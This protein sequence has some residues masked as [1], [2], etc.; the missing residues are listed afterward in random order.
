MSLADRRRVEEICHGALERDPAER[1]AFVAHACAGDEALRLEVE[2]L[3]AHADTADRFLSDQLPAAAADA[4]ASRSGTLIGQHIGSCQIV[5]L[6]GAGG[7]AEV[8]R[9][10][11]TEL[12]RDVAIKILPPSYVADRGR[13]ARFEREARAVAALNHPNIVTIHSIEML[14]GQPVLVMELVEGRSLTEV[15]PRQGLP[16]DKFVQIA[17]PLADAIGTAHDKGITHRDLK[18]GNVMVTPEGRVKVLDFGL[19][20][21]GADTASGPVDT[22]TTAGRIVGTVAYMSPEQAEGREVDHRSDIFSLGI[23][24]YEMATGQQPFKGDTNVSVLASIVRDTPPSIAEI[25]PGLPRELARIVRKA[26]TKDVE[27]RYQTAKELRNDLE[28]LRDEIA[29]GETMTPAPAAAPRWRVWLWAA[30]GIAAAVIT[31]AGMFLPLRTPAPPAVRS[32]DASFAQ[33]TFQPG[34]ERF[35]SLSPDGKWVVYSAAAEGNEDIYLQSVGGQNA[36]NLTKDSPSD[37]TQPVFSPDGERIAFRSARDGGG[38]FVM[39]RTGEALRRLTRSG[40]TPS[41]SPDGRQIAYSTA[42]SP[43]MPY[44]GG[45]GELW[46]VDVA[47]GASH[48]VPVKGDHPA[49]IRQ[50]AWSPDAQRIAFRSRNPQT[51]TNAIWTASVA[52]GTAT[53]FTSDGASEWLPIWSADG[54]FLYCSS[55]RDGRLN[56]W[57]TPVDARAGTATGSPE[58]IPAPAGQATY[59]SISADGKHIAYSSLTLQSNVQKLAVDPLTLSVR[60]GM[61]WL[62]QG[63]RYWQNVR[64]SP[65][66][67]LLALQTGLMRANEI[68]VAQA[69]GASLRQVTRGNNPKWLPD[70]RTIIFEVPVPARSTPT[71]ELSSIAPDG[72]ELATRIQSRSTGPI[73]LSSDGN[74]VILHSHDGIVTKLVVFDIRNVPAR[75]TGDSVGS[76]TLDG[77]FEP[78]AWS[79]DGRSIAG[80]INAQP[81]GIVVFSIAS[82]TASR[83]TATGERPHWLDDTQLLYQDR[84]SLQLVDVRTRETREVFSAAPDYIRGFDISKD[85]QSLYVARG[86]QEADIWLATIK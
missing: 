47:S 28:T 43:L 15:I 75:G 32:V 54:R 76:V 23:V 59:F 17:I 16:L 29:S 63:S 8:Y 81:G 83:I 21:L 6:L 65:D 36:I 7:M 67:S 25:R 60:P 35:P 49:G 73:L 50:P 61:Q 10:R 84:T 85:R 39:G 52:D 30:A 66:A 40:F 1:R 58:R 22:L 69:D 62:T 48:Q 44:S 38:L 12:R 74:R 55:D 42:D 77:G 33:I 34:M 80:Q 2:A 72:S 79:P 37:D 24:L 57:R 46:I 9:A 14:D 68:F 56:L 4:L 86:A 82:K 78:S 3:L 70:G 26:L 51:G 20:K 13:L 71:F 27:R 19:S 64:V 53:I 31:G 41:W 5:S 11:D 45:G 18:P